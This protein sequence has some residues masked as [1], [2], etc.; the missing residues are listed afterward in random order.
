V[1]RG[2]GLVER[3]IKILGGGADGGGGRVA[4]LEGWGRTTGGRRG[5]SG[6]KKRG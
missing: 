1:G 3:T 5:D 2:V 4:S 6:G